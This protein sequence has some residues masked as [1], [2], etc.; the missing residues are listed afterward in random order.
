[1]D[2][3]DLIDVESI[4]P[5]AEPRSKKQALQE[6]ARMAEKRTGVKYDRIVDALLKRERL[7][8]TGVGHGVAIPHAKLAKLDGIVGL[9]ARLRRPVD[10]DSVDGEPVDLMFL[11]LAPEN[12]SAEHLKALAEVSRQLRSAPVRDALRQAGSAD[13]L[14][15]AL[16]QERAGAST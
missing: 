11:L 13:G 2:M 14:Y 4:T 9:F 1:M 8:S 5:S 3:A 12:A 15:Q 7:G 6:I 10:F 16:V